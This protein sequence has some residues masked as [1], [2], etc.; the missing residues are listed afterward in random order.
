MSSPAQAQARLPRILDILFALAPQTRL[1]KQTSWRSGSSNQRTYIFLS[2][3]TL[4]AKFQSGAATKKI[5]GLV[6]QLTFLT[7]MLERCLGDE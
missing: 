4:R 5:Y 3:A 7:E 2:Q 6:Q 1:F